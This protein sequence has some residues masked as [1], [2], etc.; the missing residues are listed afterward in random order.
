MPFRPSRHQTRRIATVML[1]VWLFAV[2]ASWAHACI[3]QPERSREHHVRSGLVA[4]PGLSHDA[5]VDAGGS[6]LPDSH[7]PDPAQQACASFCD[8]EQSIVTKAQPAKGDGCAEP[9]ALVALDVACWPAFTRGRAEVRWRP[10]AAPPPPGP[11][12]AI[13]FL[14]LTI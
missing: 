14:R 7:L 4:P 2:V 5:N 11:P 13:A 6:H 1:F 9:S 12:V 3:L 8:T 10:L